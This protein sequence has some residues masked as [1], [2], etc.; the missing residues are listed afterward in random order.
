MAK[1]TTSERNSLPKR[2]FALEK[3]RKFPIENKS[4]ARDAL[5]RAAAKGGRIERKVE[6][7]VHEKFPSIRIAA[8]KK[9]KKG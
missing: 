4:H 1:L 2:D 9:A 7:A 8:L 3:A 5:A 6:K